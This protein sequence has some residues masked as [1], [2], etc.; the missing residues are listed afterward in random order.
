MRSAERLDFQEQQISF[1]SFS[2]SAQS[3]VAQHDAFSFLDSPPSDK[4]FRAN[5]Q[6][7]CCESSGEGNSAIPLDADRD[8]VL[9]G[10]ETPCRL[11]H[12]P[13]T[14][15]THSEGE[16][17]KKAPPLTSYSSG[18][19]KEETDTTSFEVVSKL[20]RMIG[21]GRTR[22]GRFAQGFRKSWLHGFQSKVEPKFISGINSLRNPKESPLRP[23]FAIFPLQPPSDEEVLRWVSEKDASL[24]VPDRDGLLSGYRHLLGRLTQQMMIAGSYLAGFSSVSKE[25]HF[26]C[27]SEEYQTRRK[28]IFLQLLLDVQEFF[29][30]PAEK[31]TEKLGRRDASDFEEVR[32]LK[33]LFDGSAAGRKFCPPEVL[34]N[35]RNAPK[36]FSAARVSLP[37]TS[38]AIDPRHLLNAEMRNAYE[39]PPPS[40]LPGAGRG[41]IN[42][43]EKEW[44]DLLTRLD[45]INALELFL[46]SD[47]PKDC[48]GREISAGFFT[49]PKNDWDERTI[50]NR[51]SRNKTEQPLGTCAATMSYGPA[52]CDLRLRRGEY[53][54]GSGDDLPDFYHTLQTPETRT[55]LNGVGPPL[56]AE[57]LSKLCPAA[58]AR[59]KERYG[60][61]FQKQLQPC[62][63]RLPMGD[64]NAVDF[65]QAI[66]ANA[67]LL[68]GVV[69]PEEFMGINEP[70]PDV[71]HGF[72]WGVVVDDLCVCQICREDGTGPNGSPPLDEER[73][74]LVDSA[75]A[76][77]GLE[78]KL[79]KRYRFLK[80][81]V[82]WGAE[83]QGQRGFVS[84]ARPFIRRLILLTLR[85]L[86][87]RRATMRMI[88]ALVG[89]WVHVLCYRRP[90]FA[91]LF[92]V[93]KWRAELLGARTLL[94]VELT[95]AQRQVLDDPVVVPARVRE[96][97]LLLCLFA[98]LCGTHIRADYAA[99]LHATDA[100]S[101]SSATVSA[102]VDEHLISDLYALRQR[103][104][105][106]VRLDSPEFDLLRVSSPELFAEIEKSFGDLLEYPPP[107]PSNPQQASWVD[108]M[109]SVL[110]WELQHK[111]S[112]APRSHINEKEL[113][114]ALDL[115]SHLASKNFSNAGVG[116][117]GVVLV[118]SRVALGALTKGR[119]SSRR[120]NRLLKK[121]LPAALFGRVYL[122][123]LYVRSR[124]NPADDPTRGKVI[125]RPRPGSRAWLKD[126]RSRVPPHRHSFVRDKVWLAP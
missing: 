18:K 15:L 13:S 82:S 118:D 52:F 53:L 101:Y 97:L 27:D 112:R 104:A 32:R 106:D 116:V 103:R 10:G 50:C 1:N 71:D 57:Q 60:E 4:H 75:Y 74:A 77:Q 35:S 93:Y 65:A 33:A 45:S 20:V 70:S 24:S 12:Q 123:G 28:E 62:L 121:K 109:A 98:P 25:K 76:T 29:A 31:I 36:P 90:M 91:L 87:G 68:G 54:R 105:G 124:F 107:D 23:P 59:A 5:E 6:E 49:L 79:S 94:E 61:D 66:H 63:S 89:L 7:K 38:A 88:D 55:I 115:Q 21:H 113:V 100:S 26:H 120:L 117:R 86:S 99:E 39:N 58:F 42:G 126:L 114:E 43:A 3:D 8:F 81:F 78:A 30:G 80:D 41:R 69:R 95:S 37:A 2:S 44:H 111:T 125:R 17:A 47:C 67:L 72:T 19:A 96:E 11:L 84:A 40:G 46:R 73:I 48:N 34:Q 56:T 51:R 22:L 119:S 9:P 83:V 122:G 14:V 108:E 92:E 85:T 110:T 16:F 102:E 64:L